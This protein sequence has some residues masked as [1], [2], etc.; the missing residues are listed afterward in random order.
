MIINQLIYAIYYAILALWRNCTKNSL[1]S[2]L[3]WTYDPKWCFKKGISKQ[4]CNISGGGCSLIS[5]PPP[6]TGY[7]TEVMF[8]VRERLHQWSLTKPGS[9]VR[10]SL[11]F[12]ID[13]GT[14]PPV[15]PDNPDSLS[16][17]RGKPLYKTFPDSLFFCIHI[18]KVRVICRS[19]H[20]RLLSA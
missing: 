20:L 10:K 1:I 15:V 6:P 9:D 19:Q 16:L 4:C 8:C 3:Y 14:R 11:C 5:H 12:D 13:K 2:S 7:A 18:F 17:S